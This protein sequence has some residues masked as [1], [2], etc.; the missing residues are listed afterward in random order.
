MR[1]TENLKCNIHSKNQNQKY[2]SL[3]A[4]KKYTGVW[5]RRSV[6]VIYTNQD[7]DKLRIWRSADYYSVNVKCCGNIYIFLFFTSESY[8]YDRDIQGKG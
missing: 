8:L 4:L 6:E 1:Q 2:V 5:Q 7:T 3:V